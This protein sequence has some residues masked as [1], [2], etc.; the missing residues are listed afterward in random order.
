ML[1]QIHTV[2]GNRICAANPFPPQNMHPSKL[3]LRCRPVCQHFTHAFTLIELLVVISIV[4]VLAGIALPIFGLMTQRGNETTCISNMRQVT[5]ATNLAAN[6]SNGYPNMHGF[7]WE[8]GTVWIADELNPYLGSIPNVSPAKVIH[9][10]AS[11]TNPNQTWLQ[12]NQ[13]P[14][15]KYNVFYAYNTKRPLVSA[16]NAMLFFDTTWA[17]WTPQVFSHSP[18]SGAYLNVAYADGHVAQLNYKDYIALNAT[19][20][21]QHTDF[22]ELG[23]IK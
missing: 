15:Y 19:L 18:G 21:E 16:V 4:A 13:Y 22:F 23:W 9:C 11:Q 17:D 12:D 2:T 8:P 6:D 7:A 10:P 3:S 5:M 14:G 1:L 20:D